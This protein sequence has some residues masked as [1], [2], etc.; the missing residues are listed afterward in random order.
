P[1]DLQPIDREARQVAEAGIS[2]AD[3]VDGDLY[4]DLPQSCNRVQ[5]AQLPRHQYAFRHFQ[6]QAFDGKAG[7]AKDTTDAI[8]EVAGAKL[9]RGNVDAEDDGRAAR[10]DPRQRGCAGPLEDL[11]ADRAHEQHIL[12]DA[13]TCRRRRAWP[14]G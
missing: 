12:P 14:A 1:H 11:V 13:E 3:V 10:V 2:G 4:A 6:L 5:V 8:H 7:R 9:E